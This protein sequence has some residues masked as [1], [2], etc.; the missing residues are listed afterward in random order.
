MRRARDLYSR[1]GQVA[2]K[3]VMVFTDYTKLSFLQNA[4]DN[5]ASDHNIQHSIG[6]H[7]MCEVNVR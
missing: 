7:Q 2:T 5:L 1:V 6:T 4:I 3:I